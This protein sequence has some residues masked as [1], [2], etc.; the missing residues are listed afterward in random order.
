MFYIK[1]NVIKLQFFWCKIHLEQFSIKDTAGVC[2][3]N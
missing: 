2:I 1:I 3:M